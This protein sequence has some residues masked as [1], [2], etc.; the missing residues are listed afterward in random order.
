MPV[1]KTVADY[2]TATVFFL[3]RLW[4]DFTGIPFTILFGTQCM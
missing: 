4:L 3:L 1:K 2:Q